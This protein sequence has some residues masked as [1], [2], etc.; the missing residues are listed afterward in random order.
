MEDVAVVVVYRARDRS[1]PPMAWAD[2]SHGNEYISPQR[3]PSQERGDLK[4]QES[5][6]WSPGEKGG[7]S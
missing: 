7:P 6:Q 5:K 3:R 4:K 1:Y 2:G